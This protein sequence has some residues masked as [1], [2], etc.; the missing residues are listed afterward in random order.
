[1]I[2]DL[3]LG[4]VVVAGNVVGTTGGTQPGVCVAVVQGTVEI[5]YPTGRYP[6][7]VEIVVVADWNNT[8]TA[9][10]A[11]DTIRDVDGDLILG[12]TCLTI[13][14]FFQHLA[15][16]MNGKEDPIVDFRKVRALC[17]QDG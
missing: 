1:M 17:P 6:V 14:V 10:A 7:A 9:V 2:V 4:V 13:I 15:V 16:R 8:P 11:D 5:G 12:R 3:V